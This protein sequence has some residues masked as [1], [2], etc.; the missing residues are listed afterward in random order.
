M[1]SKSP[2]LS[3]GPP[4]LLRE[5]QYENYIFSINFHLCAFLSGKTS[6]PRKTEE[7]PEEDIQN[8]PGKA[9][10]SVG[11]VQPRPPTAH[12]NRDDGKAGKV[13]GNQVGLKVRQ[14]FISLNDII[15]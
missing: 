12:S 13:P 6:L 11:A 9:L 5:V 14:H 3:K 10:Q 7:I 8:I 2:C 4:T 15:Y 1:I